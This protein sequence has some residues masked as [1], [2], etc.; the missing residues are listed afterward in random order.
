MTTDQNMEYNHFCCPYAIWRMQSAWKS[1][2]KTL[3][4]VSKEKY[5]KF[6]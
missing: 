3:E 6:L 1:L 4:E 2:E 5:I